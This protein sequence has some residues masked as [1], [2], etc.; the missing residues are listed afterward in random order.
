MSPLP[1]LCVFAFTC[2]ATATSAP[3]HLRV[4]LHQSTRRGDTFVTLDAL[5]PLPNTPLLLSWALPSSLPTQASYR[6]WITTPTSATAN[7]TVLDSGFVASSAPR[8]L[9][10]RSL[11]APARGYS[12][13]VA[14]KGGDGA[15][16]A[17]AVPQ[18]FFTS[19]GNATWAASAPIWAPPCAGAQAPPPKFARFHAAV[20]LPAGRAVLSALMYI[21]GSPPIY[22]DPWNVT[23]LLGGYKLSLNNTV[24]GVG[25]G[26]TSCG[27]LRPGNHQQ[28]SA[29]PGPGLC[30]P[31][32]PVDGYDV[33]REVAA[34]LAAAAPL[35]VGVDSYGLAQA[36]FGLVPAVQAALHIRWAPEGSAPDTI[37]GTSTGGGWL[38]LD[39]DALYSP[40]GNKAPFWYVQPREDVNA[41]CLP[42][43]PA[44]GW[45]AAGSC[46]ACG[47][48]APAPAPGAWLQGTLPLAGKTTQALSY[49][50]APPRG[51][52]TAQLG[53][54]WFRFDAGS[55]FQGGVRLALAPGAPVP[56]G[57][58]IATVQLSSQVAANGSALWNTRAGNHYQ[59]RWAFPAPAGARP[60]QRAIEHHEYCE[61][62]YA[63]VIWRDAAS[64]APLPLAAGADFFLD[65]WV[66][67]Y[68]YD[69]EG[70]ATVDTSS[71]ELNAVF[72]L[73]ANTIKTTTLD[74]YADSNTRQRSI[75]CMADDTTA[76]L[77]HYGT[78]TELA[79][80]RMTAGQIMGITALGYISGNWADWTI[81]PGLNVYYD[82]LFTGDLTFAAQ[83]FD[84]LLANHTYVRLSDCG[85]AQPPPSIPPA[86]PTAHA[87]TPP[88]PSCLPAPPPRRPS[89]WT[90]P[91]TWCTMATASPR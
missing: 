68:P 28:V 87:L 55:E 4:D 44:A 59:D 42:P 51:D 84:V 71:P 31:V 49:S 33:S 80:Q 15:V 1:I 41:S 48:A 38:A 73:A 85:R 13:T 66:V 25:P 81:L 26:R 6:V 63:E 83:Y 14:V 74:F 40:S 5:Y 64:G 65:F 70:A 8:A 54:G 46:S 57:G 86:R 58:A 75:D 50:H 39:A 82:A 72:G 16:S 77:N 47:W 45:S 9:V 12:W 89:S 69:E 61:F 3:F 20:P 19:G 56:P 29:A 90:P 37:V 62:R 27:P 11:L 60:E 24:R 18:R 52:A 35:L 2:V 88:P 36:E 76:A 23:K 21:T 91:P 32:Q 34:A 7:A 17:W 22:Q 43:L 30:T 53:P 78:T 79:F 10:P 67:R